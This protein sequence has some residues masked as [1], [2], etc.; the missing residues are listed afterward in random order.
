VNSGSYE[1]N[2]CHKTKGK[3]IGRGE[4]LTLNFWDKV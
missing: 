2:S 3:K 1:E 4:E